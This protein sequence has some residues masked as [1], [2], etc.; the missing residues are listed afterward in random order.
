MS[1]RLGEVFA[2]VSEQA[3]G[4][5]AGLSAVVEHLADAR[6]IADLALGEAARQRRDQRG[7]VGAGLQK[8]EP[9]AESGDLKDGQPF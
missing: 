3:A 1:T 2:E 8:A 9:L 4:Q 6:H 7:T 5:T